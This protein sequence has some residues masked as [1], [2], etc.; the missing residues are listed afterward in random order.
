MPLALER[1]PRARCPGL[2]AGALGLVAGD[3]RAVLSLR[4]PHPGSESN[5]AQD[6]EAAPPLLPVQLL[7]SDLTMTNPDPTPEELRIVRAKRARVGASDHPLDERRAVMRLRH[8]NK[9]KARDAYLAAYAAGTA[10]QAESHRLWQQQ[11]LFY[12]RHALATAAREALAVR[13]RAVD[14]QRAA[15]QRAIDADR[16]VAAAAARDARD[17][18]AGSCSRTNSAAVGAARARHAG[19]GACAGAGGGAKHCCC[20]P[21][22]GRPGRERRRAAAKTRGAACGRRGMRDLSRRPRRR[23]A[24]ARVRPQ[25]SRGLHEGASG[26]CLGR[27]QCATDPPWYAC[28]VSALPREIANLV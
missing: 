9:L 17:A 5:C 3:R 14:A 13:Q 10:Q 19:A 2:S 4:N 6:A 22:R 24:G 12:H 21:G 27:W 16:K 15:E 23:V 7:V 1:H 25:V 28:A 8:A 26:S 20:S 11:Q 18:R